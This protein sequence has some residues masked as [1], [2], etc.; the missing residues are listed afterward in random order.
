MNAFA[1]AVGPKGSKRRALEKTK[2]DRVK[3]QNQIKS[4]T[5]EVGVALG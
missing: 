5:A 3:M 1:V 2:H 4:T